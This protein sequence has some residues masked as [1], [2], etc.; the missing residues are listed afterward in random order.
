MKKLT[1]KDIRKI[2]K[3]N[4]KKLTLRDIGKIMNVSHEAIRK[5]LSKFS[6]KEVDKENQ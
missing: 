4:E 1:A 6:T 2:V 3:L 5:V